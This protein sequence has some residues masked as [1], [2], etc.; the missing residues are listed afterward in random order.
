MK[1]ACLFLLASSATAFTTAP[2][3]FNNVRTPTLQLFAEGGRP[4]SSG[5][6]AAALAASKKYGA[7]SPE[8]RVAWEA[9]EDM[10]ASDNR[11]VVGQ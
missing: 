10:D 5:A 6:V 3:R 4:D 1:I 9:V 7:T 11:Y 8:A 2:A